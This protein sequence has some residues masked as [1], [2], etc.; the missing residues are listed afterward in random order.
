[1]SVIALI[2]V[3]QVAVTPLTRALVFLIALLRAMLIPLGG[4]LEL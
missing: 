3:Q 1:M 2:N 4:Q